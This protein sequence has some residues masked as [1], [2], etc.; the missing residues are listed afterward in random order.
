MCGEVV[1]YPS[2]CLTLRKVNGLHSFEPELV[3]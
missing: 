1:V 3:G 2:V